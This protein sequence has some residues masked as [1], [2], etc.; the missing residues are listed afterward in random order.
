MPLIEDETAV[1][2]GKKLYEQYCYG[3]HGLEVMGGGV[4]PDLRFA[5]EQTFSDWEG[6]V[7]GGSRVNAGMRSFAAV[8]S[9]DD[10]LAIRTYVLER[11]GRIK[12]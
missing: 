7:I 10:A 4:I 12:Q 8:M 1:A 11:A 5:D 6:I 2:Q 9:T 3:C